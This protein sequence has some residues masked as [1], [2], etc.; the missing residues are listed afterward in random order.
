MKQGLHID[1][2][3]V[4]FSPQQCVDTTLV[5]VEHIVLRNHPAYESRGRAKGLFAVRDIPAGTYLGCYAGEVVARDTEVEGL[6]YH[7]IDPY[8]DCSYFVDAR[9]VRNELA[10]INDFRGIQAAPSC[11]FNTEARPIMGDYYTACCVTLR[12]IAAGEE[13]LVDYG[14][15]YWEACKA[16]YNEMRPMTCTFD[17]CT[18]RVK[19]GSLYKMKTH[20][21]A[22]HTGLGEYVCPVEGCGKRYARKNLW[23]IHVRGELG[24]KPYV[25]EPCA[26]SF[27]SKDSLR[28]HLNG[29]AH[30]PPEERIWHKCFSCGQTFRSTGK[31]RAHENVK[32]AERPV[33]FPCPTCG[34]VYGRKDALRAHVRAVHELKGLVCKLCPEL[35]AMTPSRYERHCRSLSHR[36]REEGNK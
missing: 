21:D 2:V 25:C 18:Y 8:D 4:P 30:I 26:L 16:H 6:S 33:T 15:S 34:K 17:G 31:L 14:E 36:M 10:Y 23:K 20:V 35:G 32:H 9:I 22:V 3:F 29:S 11:K 28:H 5:R 1:G 13:L 19:S 27:T 24:V 7:C 12:D